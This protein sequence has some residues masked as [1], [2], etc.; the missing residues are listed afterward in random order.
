ML[1]YTD[2][3]MDVKLASKV[4]GLAGIIDD[5]KKQILMI[6]DEC[7]TDIKKDQLLGTVSTVLQLPNCDDDTDLI[8][9][10]STEVKDYIKLS[11]LTVTQQAEVFAVLSKYKE[12]LA[13]VI[14]TLAMQQLL[15]T[16]LD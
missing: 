13:R 6:A 7:A 14:L 12:F 8:H 1:L 9:L 11:E 16:T 3:D 4:C 15:S 5:R 2:C 10:S